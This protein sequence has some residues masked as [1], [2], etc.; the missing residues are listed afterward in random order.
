MTNQARIV[1]GRTELYIPSGASEIVYVTPAVGPNNYQLVGKQIITNGLSV[2][3]GDE[4]APLIHQA[5]AGKLKDETELKEVRDIAQKRFFW[6]FNRNLWTQSGMFST[7]DREA[8]GR[9][10]AL[11]EKVLDQAIKGGL[12]RNGVLF[13]QDGTVRFAPKGSYTLGEMSAEQLAK[14]GAMI[15]QYGV[16]GAK[17][18]AEA[19]TT[20][21]NKPIT[22]GLN[23]EKGQSSETR[24]STLGGN[25]SRLRFGGYDWGGDGDGDGY[26]FG[27]RAL[28]AQK[29]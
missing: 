26:A 16:E 28:S 23:I 1:H 29:I 2:P 6:A 25:D 27:V 11:D 24:V 22:Y 8:I 15:A 7:T 21:K 14:D 17:L 20:R 9:S 4:T 18:L 10:Q 19:S 12:D 13:S 3:I 5:Y